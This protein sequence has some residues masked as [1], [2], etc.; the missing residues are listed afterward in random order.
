MLYCSIRIIY[1]IYKTRKK[2]ATQELKEQ[3]QLKRDIKLSVIIVTIDIIFL[4]LNTP[5]LIQQSFYM[6]RSSSFIDGLDIRTVTLLNMFYYFQ[7]A[8]N[9]F[10]YMI[11]YLMFRK[12]FLLYIFKF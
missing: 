10:I 1:S 9:F 11:V 5:Q 7:Y 2:Q 3:Q 8:V 6:L 12:W 4:I